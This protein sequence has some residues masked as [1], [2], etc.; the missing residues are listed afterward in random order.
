MLNF[1]FVFNKFISSRDTLEKVLIKY[2][3]A[4]CFCFWISVLFAE[5][6]VLSLAVYLVT[7]AATLVVFQFLFFYFFNFEKVEKNLMLET[8]LK[9]GWRRRKRNCFLVNVLDR[10]CKDLSEQEKGEEKCNHQKCWRTKKM[11][12]E[13]QFFFFWSPALSGAFARH[14]EK[15]SS[16]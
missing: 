8:L 9:R 5:K 14:M 13:K 4:R 12:Q 2:S 15:W 11:T 10:S 7:A 6:Y 3:T 16:S 1:S